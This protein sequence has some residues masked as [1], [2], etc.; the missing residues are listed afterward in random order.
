VVGVCA[1]V[2][3]AA[4]KPRETGQLRWETQ[5][6][7]KN[8]NEGI[9]IADINRDGTPDIIS[10]PYWFEGPRWERHP[11]RDIGIGN[12]EFFQN[13]GDH[14]I[15]L[16]GDGW[17]D[18][19]SASWFTDR[20]Y[21]Y[22]N[23]GREGLARGEK[24]KQHDVVGGQ[25]CCEGT[26]LE[27]IDG[28][29]VPELIVNSWT[30]DKPLTVVKITPGKDGKSPSFEVIQPGGPGYG[31]G[32]SVGDINGDGRKDIFTNQGWYEQPEKDWTK[33]K[34]TFHRMFDYHHLSLPGQIVDV[35][36]DGKN[37]VF[38]GQG[39][40]Y[41]LRWL[42]QGP[43]RDGEITWTEHLIDKSYSQ[44]HCIAWADLDGDGKKEFITGKRWRGHKGT[45]PGGTEPVCLYRYVWNAKEKKFDRDTISY[46]SEIGTGMQIQIADLNGDK[47]PDIAVAGKTGTWLLFNKG[48]AGHAR[49]SP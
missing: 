26:V 31:H 22:E 23:P 38:T 10:G 43:V 15:D 44:M 39:H 11:V 41:E 25:N 32:V 6:L 18:D 46:D 29:K 12:D 37:D 5:R 24:W 1:A 33:N 16:N 14:A 45:D 48:P 49:M 9:D 35:N 7:V 28:D 30:E 27:D 19:L 40:N 2:T 4:P 3:L 42:E 8:L 13:N 36:G 17:V 21:W 47:R 20:I 34:W